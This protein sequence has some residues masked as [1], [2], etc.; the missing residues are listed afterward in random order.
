MKNILRHTYYS[1]PLLQSVSFLFTLLILHGIITTIYLLIL[2]LVNDLIVEH[3]FLATKSFHCHLLYWGCYYAALAYQKEIMDSIRKADFLDTKMFMALF[4]SFA[5]C[6]I[7]TVFFGI[8]TVP[9]L[10]ECFPSDSLIISYPLACDSHDKRIVY[11]VHAALS[12]AHILLEAIIFFTI[13]WVRTSS[14]NTLSSPDRPF[15]SKK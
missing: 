11:A 7:D 8:D 2:S 1:S 14:S 4:F 13:L 5:L 9:T 6:A 3:Y 12:I 10:M 15:T